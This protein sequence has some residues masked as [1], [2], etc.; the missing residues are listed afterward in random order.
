MSN[1]FKAS[2]KL[3][4]KKTHTKRLEYVAF[5]VKENL[6]K[7][8]FPIDL[9]SVAYGWHIMLTQFTICMFRMKNA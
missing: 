1:H 7:G 9:I 3:T 8:P 2:F 4:V 5:A 6:Y